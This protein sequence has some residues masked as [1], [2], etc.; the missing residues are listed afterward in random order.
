MELHCVL[1][2]NDAACCVGIVMT[3]S[4]NLAEMSEYFCKILL[5]FYNGVINFVL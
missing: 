1:I 3:V 2:D 5:T 4:I